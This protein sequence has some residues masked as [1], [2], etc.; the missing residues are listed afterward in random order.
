MTFSGFSSA[1]FSLR[2]LVHA[3]TKTH[4]LKPAL[5]K[6]LRDFAVVGSRI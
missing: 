4:R 6:P 3:R 1:C 5:L 2:G